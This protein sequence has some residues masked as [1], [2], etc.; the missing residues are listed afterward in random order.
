MRNNVLSG[1]FPV[2]VCEWCLGCRAT[3][4]NM[5]YIELQAYSHSGHVVSRCIFSV[6]GTELR[7]CPMVHRHQSTK[8]G[9]SGF[10][11]CSVHP[12][13]NYDYSFCFWSDVF[14]KNENKL[15]NIIEHFD[16]SGLDL[17]KDFCNHFII[18][19][20]SPSYNNLLCLSYDQCQH[21]TNFR[22]L[23]IDAFILE[24][25]NMLTRYHQTT[26]SCSMTDSE[27]MWTNT[28]NAWM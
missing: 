4:W 1:K 19:G 17:I 26:H 2:G 5:L 8:F 21:F 16:V 15:R 11:L 14:I 20:I 23:I 22:Y 9:T 27:T 3:W 6:V 12:C 25:P 24:T 18:N 7:T 10:L 13:L 28:S